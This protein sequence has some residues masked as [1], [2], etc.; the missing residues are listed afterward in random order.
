MDAYVQNAG[1]DTTA[2]LW[3]E[4]QMIIAGK[5]AKEMMEA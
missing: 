3:K 2:G 4:T 5:H 1:I